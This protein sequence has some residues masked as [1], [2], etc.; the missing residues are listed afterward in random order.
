VASY[1]GLGLALLAVLWPRPEWR[2]TPS[3]SRLIAS[4]IESPV[5]VSLPLL[6]RDLALYLEQL[7]AENE[8]LHE[9]L[10]GYFRFGALLLSL[11]ILAWV[12]DFVVRT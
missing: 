2:A 11:E 3:P 7:R 9:R 12:L 1:A 8:A 6:H 5:P 10:S 4:V